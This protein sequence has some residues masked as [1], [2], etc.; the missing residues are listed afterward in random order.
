MN[1]VPATVVVSGVLVTVN[2][3]KASGVTAESTVGSMGGISVGST[4]AIV[5]MVGMTVLS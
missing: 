3:D 1:E 4:V 2:S 5:L